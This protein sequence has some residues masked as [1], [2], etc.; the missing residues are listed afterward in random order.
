MGG[1]G[2]DPFNSQRLD[3]MAPDVQALWDALEAL[4]LLAQQKRVLLDDLDISKLSVQDMQALSELLGDIP[5]SSTLVITAKSASFAGS[6]G[7]KKLIALAI[8]HGGAVELSIRGQGDLV[9][10]LQSGAKKLGCQLGGQ[11]ARHM[12][13]ICPADMLILQNE[14]QKV[15]AYAGGGEIS[16]E[17]IDAMVTPKTE[18][19]AFDLQRLILQGNAGKALELLAGLFFLR[20]DPIA[21]LGALSMSFCDLYRARISKDAGQGAAFMMK[22]YGCK[23]EYRAKKAFENAGKLSTQSAR[24]A[25]KLLCESDA[26]MKS[27]GVDNKIYLEQLTVRLISVCGGTR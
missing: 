26:A 3:G 18:A 20:E 25:I 21:I 2:D 11:A 23:S 16:P 9:K 6:A 19:R 13:S 1:G 7:G 10:F 24:R 4:P 8:E 22:A 12:L 5:E 15:C 14:L 17:Q 27:T